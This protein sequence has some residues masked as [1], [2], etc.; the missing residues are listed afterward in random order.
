MRKEQKQS[1]LNSF[2]SAAWFWCRRCKQNAG[3]CVC[4]LAGKRY[5][6]ICSRIPLPAYDKHGNLAIIVGW[7]GL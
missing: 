1:L 7:I 4:H 6:G 2:H 5:A 3:H